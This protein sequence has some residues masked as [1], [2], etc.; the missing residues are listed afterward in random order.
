MSPL[1][2]S[3]S[4]PCCVEDGAR[5]D[6]RRHLERDARREVRLDQAGDDVDRRPLRREDQVDADRARLLREARDRV[7]DVLRRH[8]HQ[9]GEL[10]D[11]DDDV[12]GSGSGTRRRLAVR[13]L[14]ARGD[15]ASA[16]LS[17]ALY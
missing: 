2:S 9:V 14:R 12:D 6:L 8:H 10:V 1:P 16:S 7:L 13:Q 17:S 15:S 4:A 5:V 3:F 11:D